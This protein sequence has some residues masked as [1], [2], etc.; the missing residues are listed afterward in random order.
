MV[1]AGKELK[2]SFQEYP[3]I[4]WDRINLKPFNLIPKMA[5]GWLSKVVA[6]GVVSN[7]SNG[8][9]GRVDQPLI[10]MISAIAGIEISRNTNELSQR[11][12]MPRM[13]LETLTNSPRVPARYADSFCNQRAGRMGD[14]RLNFFQIH[15]SS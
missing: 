2:P 3:V 10:I 14:P 1:D 11:L 12:P 5:S 9:W 7:C 15:V 13:R 6:A 8:D 4:P